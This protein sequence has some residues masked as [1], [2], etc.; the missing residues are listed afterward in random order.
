MSSKS[1]RILPYSE[2]AER[3]VLG[4][5]LFDPNCVIDICIQKGVVT[6]AFYLRSHQIIYETMLGM[7]HENRPIDTLTLCQR[8]KALKHIDEVGGEAFIEGLFDSTPTVAHAEY[9]AELV[10]QQHLL[11]RIIE[12]ARKSIDRCYNADEDPSIILGHVEQDIFEIC[13]KQA[14]T[15]TDWPLLVRAAMEEVE[16]IFQ[17]RKGVGTGISTG[18]RDL[19][20]KLIGMKAGEMIVL[21]ARPS[22]GKTSLALNIAEHVATVHN[23]DPKPRP[24]AVFS[25][26]MSGEQLVRRMLC[27]HARVPSHKLSK[28]YIGDLNHRDLANAA[29]ALIKAPLFL[30][31]AAG[32]EVLDLRSRARRLHSRKNIELIVIDY[33][34]LLNFSQHAREGRQR[35]TS[36]ISSAIKAMAK[37]LKVPVLVLSQLSRAPETRG[38]SSAPKLS[39][40]RDSG[41]IEQDADVVLMLRRPCKYPDDERSHDKTLAIVD[42]A[43]NRNGPTGPVELNFSDEFTRFD[44]RMQGVD[45]ATEYGGE[46][47]AAPPGD[48]S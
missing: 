2:E 48:N 21:A 38:G 4:S 1:E 32:I 5:L 12:T 23:D 42:V 39:D 35:E 22:Q 13:Q 20:E 17:T 29:D 46:V 31:D 11:R 25:L 26:E 37:E 8:L 9:Y 30:D 10:A 44:N 15:F 19:D 40:L 7:Y 24:V 36:A 3:G 28:G 43:K 6:D 18:Y 47:G 27:S 14:V 16:I 41:A 33:L 45:H 34:Q